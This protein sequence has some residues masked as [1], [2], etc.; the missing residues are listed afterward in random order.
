MN[1]K[2]TYHKMKFEHHLLEGSHYEIGQK[3]AEIIKNKKDVPMVYLSGRFNKNKSKFNNFKEA[4]EFT[5]SYCPG[6]EEESQ[7]YADVFDAK[8][9]QLMLY[10]FPFSIEHCSHFAVLPKLTKNNEILV[11]RSYEW[12]HDEETLEFRTT[13]VNGKY[14]HI[15]FSCI[16]YGRYDG[17]NDQGLCITSSAGGAWRGKF[18]S[19]SLSWDLALRVIL[20]N[21]KDVNEA[22]KLLEEIPVYGTNIFLIVDK[23]GDAVMMENFDGNFETQ[24]YDKDSENQQIIATNHYTLPDSIK[25]NEF[26]LKWL[27]PNSQKRYK[28]IEKSIQKDIGNVTQEDVRDILSQEFPNGLCCHWFS[29]YFGTLWSVNFNVTKGVVEACFGPPTHNEWFTFSLNDP[30]KRIKYDVT[31]P[32]KRI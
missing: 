3:Q 28:I 13:Q 11:G 1:E 18:K 9:D 30:I 17:L 32:D 15:G 20:D 26:N 2:Y 25:Y 22:A 7:G 16:P 4:F 24:Y 12:K 5:N 27:L 14:K 8:V 29:D 19:K 31:F 10:D 21:C 23:S 6:L